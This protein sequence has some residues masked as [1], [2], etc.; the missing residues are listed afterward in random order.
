MWFF[1]PRE[2]WGYLGPGAELVGARMATAP[3][4]FCLAPPVALQN[5]SGLIL[6]VLHRP[7]TAPL[8]AKLAPP[9]APPKKN[10][11]LRPCLGQSLPCLK[12]NAV[13][14]FVSLSTARKKAISLRSFRL[15]LGNIAQI[16]DTFFIFCIP[17]AEEVVCNTVH[18]NISY[19]HFYERFWGPYLTCADC[20]WSLQSWAV[21]WFFPGWG[22]NSGE[23]SVYQLE[24]KRKKFST[25]TLEKYKISRSSPGTAH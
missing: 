15:L 5:F 11:W 16:A 4:K 24:N 12:Q 3:Q 23:I 9:V 7:L 25:K 18:L 8:V 10:V 19:W 2:E 1:N 17:K 20:T 13:L 6:K 21:E 14:K 22:G